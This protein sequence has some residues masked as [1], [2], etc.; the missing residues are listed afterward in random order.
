MFARRLKRPEDHCRSTSSSRNYRAICRLYKREALSGTR[1]LDPLLTIQILR[2]NQ[3][4]TLTPQVH[5]IPMARP[6]DGLAEW[7]GGD[8]RGRAERL[9]G[10]LALP[11][12]FLKTLVAQRY[13]DE[14]EPY[15]ASVGLAR[16]EIVVDP[17]VAAPAGDRPPVEATDAL[18]ATLVRE[19][20]PGLTTRL[21]RARLLADLAT[22]AWADE[23][24]R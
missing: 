21:R 23:G 11:N 16:V 8:W 9:G 19:Q 10:I 7:T 22:R 20:P 5:P 18:P 14:L 1:T 15:A 17:T 4:V 12:R 3:R 13:A 6:N 2:G 24:A